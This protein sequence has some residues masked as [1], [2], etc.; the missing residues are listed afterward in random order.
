MCPWLASLPQH[1]QLPVF[2]SSVADLEACEDPDLIREALAIRESAEAVYEVLSFALA[3]QGLLHTRHAHVTF[4][5][6]HDRG[7]AGKVSISKAG[8]T[9]KT[10]QHVSECMTGQRRE[11]AALLRLQRMTLIQNDIVDCEAKTHHCAACRVREESLM[12]WVTSGQ[13]CSGRFQCF[14]AVASQWGHLRC[15]SQPQASTWPTTHS[16]PTPLSGRHLC[17]SQSVHQRVSSP[18]HSSRF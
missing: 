2:Y 4:G 18:A 12:R 8:N 7:Q 11:P 6:H 14:T 15:T 1:V 13:T 17:R 5:L 10:L 9:S 16:P 3:H